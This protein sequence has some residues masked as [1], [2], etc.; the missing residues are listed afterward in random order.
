MK[1]KNIKCFNGRGKKKVT[2]P[3]FEARPFDRS[4][5]L[6][7]TSTPP[8]AARPFDRSS[9]PTTPSTPPFEARPF[10]ESSFTRKQSTCTKQNEATKGKYV[11]CFALMNHD[12]SIL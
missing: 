5:Y 3:P 9:F 12:E 8:F 1:E 4:T 11:Y 7:V 2:A 10:D 6:T